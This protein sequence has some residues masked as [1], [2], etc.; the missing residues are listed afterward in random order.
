MSLP[1]KNAPV[2][3]IIVHITGWPVFPA[4]EAD[5]T[6]SFGSDICALTGRNGT[7]KTRLVRLLAGE[8]DWP[9]AQVTRFSRFGYLPQ[10]SVPPGALSIAQH[11]GVADALVA[12]DALGRGHGSEEQLALLNDRWTLRQDIVTALDGVGLGTTDLARPVSSLSGGEFTRMELVRL[13]LSGADFLILDEP[14]NHLDTEARAY[15]IAFIKA[16]AGGMLV[17]S[18][19][20]DVLR[21]ADRILELSS[22]G[23]ATYRGNY[24]DFVAQKSLE[25]E[26]ATRLVND[27]SRAVRI[28][29][30]QVQMSKEK[31]DKRRARG[32]RE[33][34]KRDMPKSYY[35]GRA[36]HAQNTMGK[37]KA[38]ADLQMGRAKDELKEAEVRVERFRK[39]DLAL[40]SSGVKKG[41]AL[42]RI[43]ELSWGYREAQ[44]PLLEGVSMVLEGGDSIAL[45]GV[46]GSGKS[47]LLRLIAGQLEQ[48][49]SHARGRISVSAKRLAW[50]DQKTELIEGA[51]TVMEA[52]KRINPA[53]S[54]GEAHAALARFLFRNDDAF[55][56][57]EHL[58]GGERLRTALAALLFSPEPPQLLLL[59]EPDNHLD[60]DSQAAVAEALS[61]FDGGLLIVS[62]DEAFLEDVGITGRV[63]LS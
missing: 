45:T 12:L 33:A 16:W 11:L 28:V 21:A 34:E 46:N 30:R 19:D 22:F 55:K 35:D 54:S 60:L 40:P 56:R 50:L 24:D 13:Q 5:V 39:L 63:M 6:L 47:T 4:L 23:L 59:D 58:S 51:E 53:A 61:A 18:H 1:P 31:A 10:T 26:A 38:H 15:V 29:K 3:H 42:L 27:R 32:A 37:D 14:T 8:E 36:E 9:E 62:H 57:V 43:E 44:A 48:T 25:A 2:A 49:G 52:F 41:Q 20:R 17:V 7:G